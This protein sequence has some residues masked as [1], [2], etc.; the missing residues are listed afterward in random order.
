MSRSAKHCFFPFLIGLVLFAS[1]SGLAQVDDMQ[2]K[3]R[4]A[5]SFEQAGDWERATSIYEPLYAADPQNYML[6]DGLRRCYVQ[7]KEYDRAMKLVNDRL[8]LNPQDPVL[9]SSLGGL[10][11]QKGEKSSA[12]SIWSLAVS[13]QPGNANL[14]RLVASQM[15]EMRLYEEAISIYQKARTVSGQPL[16]FADEIAVL[17]GALMQYGNAT[18]EYIGILLANPQQLSYVQSRLSGFVFRP[19]GLEEVLGAT[20]EV[21][22]RHS[23][24]VPLKTLL[25]WLY[26][27]KKEFA[28]AYEE[29]RAIDRLTRANGQEIFN[30]AQRA[31]QEQ[32][33]S[34]AARAFREFIDRYPANELFPYA[35]FGYLRALEET[36]KVSAAI[37]QEPR[38]KSQTARA[39]ESQS[40]AATLIA[41]YEAIIRDYPNTEVAAQALYRVGVIRHDRLF[42]LDMARDAFERVRS[43][44]YSP[45]LATEA[46][47]RIAEVF[48]QKNML[49]DA[50][51]EY[52]GLRQAPL[53]NLRDNVSYQIGRLQYYQGEFDSARAT[54][55]PLSANPNKDLANDALHLLYFVQENQSP[56]VAGLKEYARA[57]LLVRQQKYAEALELFNHVTKQYPMALLRDDAL[58]QIGELLTILGRLDDAITTYQSVAD[59]HTESILRDKAL[60]ALGQIF[61]LQKRDPQ[62]A[63]GAYEQILVKFP[64]SVH[65]EEARQRIRALRGD[66]L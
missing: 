50:R 56:S 8:L 29:Y 52:E 25:A 36:G 19:E 49:A 26:M 16:L 39:A 51:R 10:Y 2:L 35:R 12:D 38:G 13:T 5:Q 57:D 48:V 62:R 9:L 42:E 6:F 3:F 31:S 34:I 41:Q 46:T 30:F 18:R 43:L 24:S 21:A 7:L 15:M 14:Y 37:P 54:L 66:S 23:E 64:S 45:S 32:V 59:D 22:T 40:E 11:Y 63:I 33:F 65:V 60:M 55:Q 20:S 44:P 61:E 47:I 58:M 17:Y 53:E 27:E 28:A 4:L 1:Q